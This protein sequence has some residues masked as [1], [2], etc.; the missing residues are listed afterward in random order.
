MVIY[1]SRR[2]LTVIAFYRQG[3]GSFEMKPEEIE[4]REREWR[5]NDV[6]VL[7]IASTSAD[8]ATAVGIRA[9]QLVSSVAISTNMWGQYNCVRNK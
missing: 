1:R 3:Y 7:P 5:K 8:L 2:F 4:A 6:S 9:H